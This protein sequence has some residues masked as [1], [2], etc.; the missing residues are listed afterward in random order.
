MTLQLLVVLFVWLALGCLVAWL[1]G[2]ASDIGIQEDNAVANDPTATW[3]GNNTDVVE[4][5]EFTAQT[6]QVQII[7]LRE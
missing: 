7:L 5:P 6:R 4:R 1:I 2:K 3:C